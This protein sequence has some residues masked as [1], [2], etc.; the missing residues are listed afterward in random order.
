MG[1]FWQKFAD[2]QIC[3]F[4]RFI[5]YN[6]SQN[7]AKSHLDFDNLPTDPIISRFAFNTYWNLQFYYQ[8]PAKGYLKT[9]LA[10]CMCIFKSMLLGCA[11]LGMEGMGM[12]SESPKLAASRGPVLNSLVI[13]L[14]NTSTYSV[15]RKPY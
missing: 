6:L 12:G 11:G 3:R 4:I 5:I 9:Y 14:P 8:T 7:N 1:D 15:T 2:A 10:P 13:T